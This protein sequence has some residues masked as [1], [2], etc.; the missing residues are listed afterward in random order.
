MRTTRAQRSFRGLAERCGEDGLAISSLPWL[1]ASRSAL[2]LLVAQAM[3]DADE[4]L[5]WLCVAL[6]WLGGGGDLAEHLYR[7]VLQVSAELYRARWASLAPLRTGARRRSRA[8]PGLR[9][10]VAPRRAPRPDLGA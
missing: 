4:L 9:R 10:L 5:E 1:L 3:H 6:D 2:F 7:P 8:G